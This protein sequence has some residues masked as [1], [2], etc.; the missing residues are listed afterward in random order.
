[1]S[2]SALLLIDLQ[3]DYLAR[4]GLQPPR[5]ILVAAIATELTDARSR[6]EPVIHVRTDGTNAMPHRAAAPEVVAGS[7]GAAPPPELDKQ[8][9]E[10][11]FTKRFFSAFDAPGI[12]DALKADRKSVV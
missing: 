8:D 5:A 7:P 12:D 4:S 10:P 3:Q 11:V 1:M 2:R 9:G 6:G